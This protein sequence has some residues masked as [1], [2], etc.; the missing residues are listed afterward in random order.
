ETAPAW[1]LQGFRRSF[2]LTTGAPMPSLRF[3]VAAIILSLFS[4]NAFAACLAYNRHTGYWENGCGFS[5]IINYYASG[6]NCA[7]SNGGSAEGTAGPIGA[8]ASG[9]YNPTLKR[10]GL[11]WNSCDYAAWRKGECRLKTYR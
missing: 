7:F 1:I 4:T 8:G 2:R 3:A 9:G 6:P 10:C 5:V 11:E